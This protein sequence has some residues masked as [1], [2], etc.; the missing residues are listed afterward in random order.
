MNRHYYIDGG[1]VMD[2]AWYAHL[3]SNVNFKLTNPSIFSHG[4]PVSYYNTHIS[5]GFFLYA[6]LSPFKNLSYP[7]Q[8]GIFLGLFQSLTFPLLYFSI[9]RSF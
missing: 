9:K 8:L 2:T 5:P 7:N 6:L 4:N 1:Y 3:I